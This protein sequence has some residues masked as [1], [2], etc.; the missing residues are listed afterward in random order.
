MW[1]VAEKN[2]QMKWFGDGIDD[3]TEKRLRA[4]DETRVPR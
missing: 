2:S 1:N 4:M 3:G